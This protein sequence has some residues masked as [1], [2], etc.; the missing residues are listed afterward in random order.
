ME[1]NTAIRI[2]SLLTLMTTILP[3]YSEHGE[4]LNET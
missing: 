4:L 2:S 1:A 3:L